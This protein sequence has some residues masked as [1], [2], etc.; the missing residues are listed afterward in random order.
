MR[1][2]VGE[3]ESC[4][5]SGEDVPVFIVF[6]NAEGFVGGTRNRVSGA[7]SRRT[8]SQSPQPVGR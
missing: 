6:L 3:R 7:I 8:I 4:E 5:R 2:G 1:R